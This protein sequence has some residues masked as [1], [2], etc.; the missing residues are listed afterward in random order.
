VNSS[1]DEISEAGR[2]TPEVELTEGNRI[3]TTVDRTQGSEKP[4]KQPQG[5]RRSHNIA[6][7]DNHRRESVRPDTYHALNGTWG[8]SISTIEEPQPFAAP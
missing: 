3:N 5:S 8:S 1:T 4:S 7:Q 2:T 6:G